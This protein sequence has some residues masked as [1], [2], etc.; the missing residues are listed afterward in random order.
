MLILLV[1]W[2]EGHVLRCFYVLEGTAV[3]KR[4][5]TEARAAERQAWL[6]ESYGLLALCQELY[7]VTR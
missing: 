7:K 4:Y 1:Q 5:L 3:K 6:E 2:L